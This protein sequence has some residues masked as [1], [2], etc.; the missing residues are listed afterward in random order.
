MIDLSFDVLTSLLQSGRQPR[1]LAWFA[2]MPLGL[3]FAKG[4]ATLLDDSAALGTCVGSVD[5]LY[6]TY[7]RVY[8]ILM[9]LIR[10]TLGSSWFM[11][12]SYFWRTLM[13]ANDLVWYVFHSTYSR[14][15]RL[16][17]QHKVARHSIQLESYAYA[18]MNH[19]YVDVIVLFLWHHTISILSRSEHSYI[20]YCVFIRHSLRFTC[21]LTSREQNDIFFDT[22][23]RSLSYNRTWDQ[24]FYLS[25]AC[26]FF[27]Q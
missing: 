27:F 11:I 14:E 4:Q 26:M 7:S 3:M 2:N 5:V 23:A 13:G 18:C 8:L 20:L 19:N 25:E 6:S 17:L 16:I 21:I 24:L 10:H 12:V 22:C 15:G 1:Q 9:S